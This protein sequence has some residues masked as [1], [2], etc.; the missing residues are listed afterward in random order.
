MIYEMY[1]QIRDVYTAN[2]D[3]VS[4]FIRTDGRGILPRASRWGQLWA[5]QASKGTSLG[6]FFFLLPMKKVST[7]QKFIEILYYYTKIDSLFPSVYVTPLWS[8]C[9]G[10][11]GSFQASPIPP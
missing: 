9:G 8:L 6:D 10:K 7:P 11:A 4:V 2:K 3:G 1:V 5:R